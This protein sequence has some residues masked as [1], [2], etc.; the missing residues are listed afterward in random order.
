MNLHK[1]VN[2]LKQALSR[3]SGMVKAD[4]EGSQPLYRDR[5]WYRE[6]NNQRKQKKK[7]DWTNGCDGVIFVQATPNGVL[8]KK[9]RETI[10]KFPS[11]IKLRVVEKGGRSMQST[12]VKT[13]PG[14]SI[15][16]SKNNCFSCKNG[17]GEGGDCRTKNVGYEIGCVEC[18]DTKSV[19]YHGETSKN[20]Y[21]RG[22][23]HQE[24][25]KYKLQSSALYKH[26]QADH[27]SRMDVNYCMKV[28][29]KFR[30]TLTRQVNEGVRIARSGAEVSLN[31]K[32]EWHGRATVRL[33][34]DE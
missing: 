31:S 30:D 14:R 27:Q 2:V 19:L 23:Q 7:K 9:F 16:C 21:V 34:I 10:E 6:P 28:K 22:L 4:Q 33:V 3:F 15:G 32:A 17:K 18:S 5:S 26:A 1:K 11:D 13:N 24:N 20:A 29:S 12:L 25:Y 8:A